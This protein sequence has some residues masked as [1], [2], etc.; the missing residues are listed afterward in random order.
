MT[1][2]QIKPGMRV[3]ILWDGTGWV[4]LP[5][6]GYVARSFDPVV[7]KGVLMVRVITGGDGPDWVPAESLRPGWPGVTA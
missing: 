2:E 4:D 5:L 3:H 6:L 1:R 7:E